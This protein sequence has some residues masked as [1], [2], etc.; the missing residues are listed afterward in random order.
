MRFTSNPM[1]VAFRRLVVFGFLFAFSFLPV[2][3]VAQTGP[4]TI[5]IAAGDDMKFDKPM[6][7]AK[8]GEEI[9]IRLTIKGK[10][11]KA[12]MAHNV[13]VLALKTDAAAFAAAGV[14]ARAT[15][16][17]A[18]D[19]KAQVIAH[20][21]LAG[22]GETVE[23]TFKVPAAAGK[24]DFICSFPGHFAAGMKGTLVVGK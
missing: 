12:V 6:I 15:D 11:P 20:T 10:M 1:S 4:R 21:P 16:Y 2:R 13:V 17:I 18:A 23:I 14:Q 22:P 8:P 3:L 9:R 7:Q 19:K 5:V 24:Y